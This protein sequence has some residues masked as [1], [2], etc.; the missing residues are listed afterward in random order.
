MPGGI[1]RRAFLRTSLL[2]A[3]ALT[4]HEQIVAAS[5]DPGRNGVAQTQYECFDPRIVEHTYFLERTVSEIHRPL[6]DPIFRDSDVAR[7]FPSRRAACACGTCGWC[8]DPVLRISI[9]CC[10]MPSPTMESFGTDPSWA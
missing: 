4:A 2:A 1:D 6:P 8:P 7:S 3:G 9:T 10:A 5:A